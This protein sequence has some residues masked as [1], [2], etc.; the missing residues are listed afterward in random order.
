[1]TVMFEAIEKRVATV[2]EDQSATSQ[3]IGEL[4]PELES[5]VVQ[6]EKPPKTRAP[7]HL[8]WSTGPMLKK[9]RTR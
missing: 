2:L 5:A 9:Q 1:V 4:L 3:A 8:I 6:A 7:R